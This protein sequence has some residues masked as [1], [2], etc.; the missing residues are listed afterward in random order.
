[1]LEGGVHDHVGGG[2]HRYSVDQRWLVPHFEKMLYDNAQLTVVLLETAQLTGDGKMR[3]AAAE[4]L[5]YLQ[6]EMS[7]PAGGFFSATD[8]D[9]LNPYTKEEEEGWFFTWTEPELD[10]VLG[11]ALSRVIRTRY[12]T[13]RRGNFEHRNILHAGRSEESVAEELGMSV[14]ALRASVEEGRALLYARRLS[15]PPPLRDDKVIAAWNGLTLSAFAKAGFILRRTDYIIRAR[16]LANFLLSK[17]RGPDG[18][19]FRTYRDGVPAHHAVLEDYAFVIQGLLDLYE[20]DGDPRW[21]TEALSLQEVLERHYVDPKGGYFAS[22]DDG[23]VLLVRP[24]PDYDGAEPSGN[25]ITALNLLRLHELTT[26]DRFRVAAD[27]VFK[28]QALTLRR[29]S[30]AVPAL[31]SALDYRTDRAFEIFLVGDDH[32]QGSFSALEDVLRET[33]VPN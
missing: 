9:S 26:D 20:A 22:A 1:M 31:L 30:A 7:A 3:E 19:L 5:D 14:A 2:F 13:S 6:K 27:A 11:P 29:R 15:R 33:F 24:K 16:E 32:S 25:S 23:E 4:T 28:A 21:I 12:Q 10:E 18:R 8:A 17:M